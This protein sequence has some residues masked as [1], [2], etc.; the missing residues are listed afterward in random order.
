LCSGGRVVLGIF[1]LRHYHI[2]ALQVG[3]PVQTAAVGRD[4]YCD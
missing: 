1:V 4:L 3:S 2:I